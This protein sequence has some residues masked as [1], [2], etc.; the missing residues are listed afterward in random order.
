MWVKSETYITLR[1]QCAAQ[2]ATIEWLR[3]RVNQLERRN[4]VLEAKVGMPPMAI[5]I[6]ERAESVVAMPAA[7]RK[8]RGER[9]PS[10][11]DLISGN[12]S[13]EDMGDDE[14]R[15]LGVG[16]DSETGRVKYDGN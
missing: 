5:P 9:E 6:I 16:W 3:Q 11:Q 8:E 12:I 13:M 4:G 14:A 2:S 7:V 10:M 15:R 1:S